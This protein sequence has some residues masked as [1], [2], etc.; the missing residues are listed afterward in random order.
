MSAAR[1]RAGSE[2]KPRRIRCGGRAHFRRVRAGRVQVRAGAEAVRAHRPVRRHVVGANAAD[3]EHERLARKHGAPGLERRGRQGLCREHLQ[4]IGAGGQSSERFGH[5]R[6]TGYADHAETLR[7]VDHRRVGVRHDDELAARFAYARDVGGR[8]D[9]ARADEASLAEFAGEQANRLERSRRI[10]RHFE[11]AEAF[12]GERTC[13]SGNLFG[14]D[15]PQDGDER[16]R[17]QIVGESGHGVFSA[18]VP[19]GRRCAKGRAQ[20]HRARP[21]SAAMSAAASACRVALAKAVA[22]DDANGAAGDAG[23]PGPRARFAH[24]RV[25]SAA[26]TA[27][28]R[29]RRPRALR[30]ARACARRRRRAQVRRRRARARRRAQTRRRAARRERSAMR[31]RMLW[32]RS[33]PNSSPV[34]HVAKSTTVPR[35]TRA[36]LLCVPG[37]TASTDSSAATAPRSC[38][39]S[40]R[41]TS[42]TP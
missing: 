36:H 8:D 33:A 14:R 35:S 29:R 9:R 38:V 17:R 3:G 23:R 40:P 21:A 12:V 28:R 2:R 30:Q 42:G 25:R 1:H 22:A 31:P 7:F 11:H 5:R 19:P 37:S 18:G 34:I 13:N 41:I 24:S 20:R 15:P 10:Q 4:P 32:S 26:P 16:E 39:S 27:S 6:N